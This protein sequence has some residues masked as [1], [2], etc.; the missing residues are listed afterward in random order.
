MHKIGSGFVCG[1]CGR[2]YKL[3][4]SLRNHKKWEC[5]KEPSFKCKLCDYKAKQKMHMMRHMQRLHQQK[6]NDKEVNGSFS[7]ENVPQDKNVI[8]ISKTAGVVH[9]ITISGGTILQN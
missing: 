1:E 7:D 8:K 3:K 9:N 2:V 6:W 5:G 4:S